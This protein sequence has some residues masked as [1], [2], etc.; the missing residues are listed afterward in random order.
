MQAV[1]PT[2][3]CRQHAKY[4]QRRLCVPRTPLQLRLW[5]ASKCVAALAFRVQ[6][7]LAMSQNS[8]LDKHLQFF[9]RRC[10]SIVEYALPR[11]SSADETLQVVIPSGIMPLCPSQRWLLEDIVNQPGIVERLSRPQVMLAASWRMVCPSRLTR[12]ASHDL[13]PL[14]MRGYVFASTTGATGRWW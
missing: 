10:V 4:L 12:A 11:S 2:T 6:F 13:V 1:S 7:R 14:L 8:S 5:T 9:W 3:T